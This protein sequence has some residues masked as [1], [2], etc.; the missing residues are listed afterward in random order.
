MNDI[1]IGRVS[2]PYPLDRRG[3]HHWRGRE[4]CVGMS[5]ESVGLVGR[6]NNLLRE[7]GPLRSQL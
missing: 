4:R 3:S 7:G 5:R 6:Y 2:M 1:S